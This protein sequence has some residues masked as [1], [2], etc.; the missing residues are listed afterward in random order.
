MLT[1]AHGADSV[2][3]GLFLGYSL[4][5]GREAVKDERIGQQMTRRTDESMEQVWKFVCTDRRLIL[6]TNYDNG[7]K[8]K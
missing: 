1:K 3:S 7:S 6:Y 4:K 2:K 8:T 5:N